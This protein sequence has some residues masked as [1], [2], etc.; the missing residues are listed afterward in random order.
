[1]VPTNLASTQPSSTW[2]RFILATVACCVAVPLMASAHQHTNQQPDVEVLIAPETEHWPS[3]Y[4]PDN[5]T[6]EDY[7]GQP[8]NITICDGS[9]GHTVSTADRPCPDGQTKPAHG[10][11][12]STDPSH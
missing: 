6:L 8:N 12:W 7:D 3:N 4:V 1:M 10:S 2:R 5:Y 11:T 9:S